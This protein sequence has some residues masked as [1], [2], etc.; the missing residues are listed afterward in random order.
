MDVPLL[1]A[2]KKYTDAK[3]VPFH[4]PGHKM[5]AGFPDIYPVDLAKLDLTEIY[6]TDN[7]HYPESVIK[8]ARQKAASV[9]GADKTYFLVN[10]STCGIHAALKTICRMGDSLI[11]SRDCHKSVINGLIM[12][13]IEPIFTIPRINDCFQIP[14]AVTADEIE[15]AILNNP[16]AAGVIITSPN[17]YG[18]CCDIKGIAKTVHKY[19]KIL[20]VDEAHGAHLKFCGLLPVCAM[21]AGADICVQSAHKTLPAFTQGSYLHI[22]GSLIDVEKLE[23]NLRILQTSSPSYIILSSLD[24]AR[25]IMEYN[26]ELLLNKLIGFIYDFRYKLQTMKNLLLLSDDHVKHGQADMTRIVINVMRLGLTGYE[27]ALLLRSK[28]NIQ[29]EMSDLFNIVCIATV[30]DSRGNFEKLSESLKNISNQYYKGKKFEFVKMPLLP[31]GA[32]TPNKAYS[33]KGKKIAL[34][35]AAGAISKDMIIPFPPGVPILIPGEYITRKI[36]DYIYDIIKAGGK[37]NGLRH[38]MMV[39][40][41]D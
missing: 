23:D 40:V 30:S 2:L 28:F 39:N 11:I 3:P 38:N 19:N 6:D 36:I 22:K 17:Y 8:D 18:I 34:S 37:I 16:K 35:K 29:V 25:A 5:G 10:G 20:V 31:A 27:V 32:I 4:M 24:M 9:F 15:N 41:I 26:G 13:G 14:D 7:L 12:W 33:S 21:D 1:D